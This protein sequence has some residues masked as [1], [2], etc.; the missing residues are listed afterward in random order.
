[1]R[2]SRFL[3]AA[4]VALAAAVVTAGPSAAATTPDPDIRS[5]PGGP[6][7]SGDVFSGMVRVYSTK[8]SEV[9]GPGRARYN[10]GG[11]AFVSSGVSK[12]FT[13]RSKGTRDYAFSFNVS[14]LPST[15][16]NLLAYAVVG[17]P[18][19]PVDTQSSKIVLMSTCA[20]AEVVPEAP[21]AALIPLTLAGTVGVVLVAHR[22]RLAGQHAA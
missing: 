4:A 3:S 11:K 19:A 7:C 21:A 15:T 9:P 16:R 2:L 22:R 8:T 10:A 14:S 20:P 13:V 5:F 18:Q 1:M 17:D 12:A 6:V